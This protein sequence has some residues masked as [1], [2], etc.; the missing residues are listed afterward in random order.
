MIVSSDLNVISQSVRDYST[1]MNETKEQLIYCFDDIQSKTTFS[2][3]NSPSK[4][5]FTQAMLSLKK[6]E[7]MVVKIVNDYSFH[8]GNSADQYDVAEMLNLKG[9]SA[10]L[11]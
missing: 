8:T 5:A 10:F 9:S 3:W 6:V 4:T 11:R 7:D 1:R 2:G